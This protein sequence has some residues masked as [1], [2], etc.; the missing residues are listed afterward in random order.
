MGAAVSSQFNNMVAASKTVAS[1][2]LVA[3]P[4]ASTD[5]TGLI[6]SQNTT[7][8]QNIANVEVTNLT[9]YERAQYRG[10]QVTYLENII[11][12]LNVAYFCL[13]ALFLML[14]A[15]NYRTTLNFQNILTV[16]MLFLYPFIIFQ[17][18]Y[19]LYSVNN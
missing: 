1:S 5:I 4:I 18:E 9:N 6:K 7:L 8:D 10:V 3:K 16:A 2:Q 15:I 17:V 14:L 13:I 11:Y 19:F 12:I